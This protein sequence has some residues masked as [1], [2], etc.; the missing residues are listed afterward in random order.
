[1]LH[2]GLKNPMKLKTTLVLF[3]FNMFYIIPGERQYNNPSYFLG[4]YK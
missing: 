4:Y 3:T 2:S 1:M